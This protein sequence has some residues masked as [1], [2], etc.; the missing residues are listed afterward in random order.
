VQ[1]TDLESGR[2]SCVSAREPRGGR[3]CTLKRK[4]KAGKGLEI[5]MKARLLRLVATLAAIGAIALA[6]GASLQGF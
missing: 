3:A 4:S 1:P 5:D 6:G 2:F